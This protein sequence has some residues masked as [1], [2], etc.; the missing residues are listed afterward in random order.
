MRM[1][2]SSMTIALSR[3]PPSARSRFL[4]ASMSRMKPNV[5]ARLISRTNDVVEKSTSEVCTPPLKTG[6]SKSIVNLTLKPSN[7][8]KRANFSPSRTSTGFLTRMK[9]FGAPCSRM[10]AD[11]TRKTNGAALPSM[12]GTS[13]AERSTKQ[14]SM[15]SPARAAIRCST[16]ETRTPS[17][18]IVVASSVS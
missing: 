6:W 3:L 18:P 13:S 4:S 7:G 11:C 15:P 5:R 16:V 10:P 17:S 14:L 8:S 1:R 9:R 2:Y 12:M